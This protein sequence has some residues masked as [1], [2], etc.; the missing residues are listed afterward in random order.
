[1]KNWKTTLVGAISAAFV[2]IATYA[3]SGGD[4]ADWKLYVFPALTAIW[5]YVQKDA[6]V[7]GI[8]K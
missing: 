6:G 3:Q 1:M 4:L 8:A 5:G 2:A 7:T